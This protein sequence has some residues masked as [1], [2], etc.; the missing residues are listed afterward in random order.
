MDALLGHTGFVGTTLKSQHGFGG[1]FNSANVGET[2]GRAFSTLVCAAAPGSM[3]H[4]NRDPQRDAAN[5][6]ALIETLRAIKAQRIV[7]IST[8]ACLAGFQAESEEQ[9]RFETQTPYGRNRRRLEEFVAERHETSLIVRLPALFGP[10]LKKNFLFDL[11][12]P[13]PSMLTDDDFESLSA[14]VPKPLA[15][16]TQAIYTHDAE[17]GFHVID[18]ARLDA[19]GAR[20]QLEA[21]VSELG[22]G[23]VRFTNPESEFQFYAM[24]NLWRDIERALA[25]GLDVVHLAPV[26]LTA[27]RVH[28]ALTG[29]TM[30]A[31]KA[32]VHREDMRTAHSALWGQSGPYIA[33]ETELLGSLASFMQAERAHL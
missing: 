28:E 3:L 6:D 14:A 31:S 2:A 13:V 16:L 20:P 22:L 17:T 24:A 29:T 25:A 11:L 33:H 26:P 19:S 23:A 21:V 27:G 4:A 32:R 8:V 12:N 10:G 30:Q 1:L 5:I 7:L 15:V 18:R 9:V